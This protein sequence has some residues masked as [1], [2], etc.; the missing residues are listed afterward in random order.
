MRLEHGFHMVPECSPNAVSGVRTRLCVQSKW[1]LFG[2]V[3]QQA[4]ARA[5]IIRPCSKP[6]SLRSRNSSMDIGRRRAL[7]PASP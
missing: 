6:I 7:P 4:S 1:V 2:R 3:E 5:R